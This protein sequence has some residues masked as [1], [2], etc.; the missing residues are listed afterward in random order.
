MDTLIE[1]LKDLAK[2]G[3][4]TEFNSEKGYLLDPA[5][6]KKYFPANV[7]IV[8]HHRFEGESS[9]D[10][11]S[12]VYALESEDG[13]KGVIVNS[14]GIYSNPVI[15]EFIKKIEEHEYKQIDEIK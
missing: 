14:F 11:M 9:A 3:F 8:E 15:D 1:Q 2:R 13:V 5:S 10:D 6:N 4:S 12:V 7:K